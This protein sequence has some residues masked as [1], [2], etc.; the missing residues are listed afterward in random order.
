MTGAKILI[1][2]DEA[3]EALDIQQRLV[4]LGYPHPDVVYSGE[5]AVKRAGEIHP[6]L[7]L[8]DIM[9]PGE[10]DGVTAAAQIRT[11]FDIPVVY[12]TAYADEDTVRR[13]KVT[14]PYGY[15]VKPFQERELHINIEIALYKHKMEGELRESRE[16]FATTLRCIG[17]AVIATDKDGKITFMNQVAESLTG[18]RLAEASSKELAEVF[19]IMNRDTRQPVENPVTRVLRE[20]TVVGLANHTMLIA[21]DGAEIPIDDSG[22][23][24]KDA[25]ENIIGVVLVFRDVTE[26]ERIG[27]LK[28]EFIGLVSHEIRTPLTTVIAGLDMAMTPGMTA[29]E[30]QE[31]LSAAAD[32]AESLAHIV[33]NLVELS[34][35]QAN[36]MQ[37]SRA[38]IDVG[39][40]I[41]EIVGKEQVRSRAHPIAVDIPQTLPRVGVDQLRLEQILRNLLDNAAK[42]SPDGTEIR[43][44]ARQQADSL[45]ISVSDQGIGIA[46]D[47]QARLFQPFQR[48]EAGGRNAKGLGLGLL[49]CKR[50]VEAHDGRIWVESEPGRGST[51]YFTL[52]LDRAG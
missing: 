23:P 27:K 34:R 26:Q 48:L 41:K 40:V 50:L 5:E 12:L 14:E 11:R 43:V 29:E 25:R 16:W 33:N 47:E 46:A 30:T 35:Y 44:C 2:E 9:L 22:A 13:A 4:K 1:V 24:I 15:M 6:D 37:I 52:P 36:R 45:L 3:I 8:M 19:R 10:I 20:G 51:F 18:W 31:V 28:D 39:A 42:Y 7:V 38:P 32:G 21:R 17:D 49:V